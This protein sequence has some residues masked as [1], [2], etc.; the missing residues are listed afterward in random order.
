MSGERQTRSRTLPQD[1]EVRHLRNIPLVDQPLPSPRDV[2][3]PIQLFHQPE[4]RLETRSTSGRGDVLA[5]DDEP[6]R[7]AMR[8]AI[9]LVAMI[10][11]AGGVWLAVQLGR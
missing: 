6:D 3:T 1:H 9:G 10:V 8:T 11:L 4:R 2:L 5:I 7:R